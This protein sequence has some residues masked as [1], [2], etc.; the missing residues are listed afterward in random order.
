VLSSRPTQLGL[1]LPP[2]QAFH[3]SL[4]AWTRF[5]M[6]GTMGLRIPAGTVGSVISERFVLTDDPVELGFSWV[7]GSPMGLTRVS[8]RSST[9]SV[10]DGLLTTSKD[11]LRSLVGDEPGEDSLISVW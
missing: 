2:V 4:E 9:E 6:V 1:G 8:V 11:E 10:S 3:S 7:P 5:P